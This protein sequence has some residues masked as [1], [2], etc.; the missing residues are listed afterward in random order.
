MSLNPAMT[1]LLQFQ[2]AYDYD[3][4]YLQ[5]L[6]NDAPGAFYAFSK[7]EGM[8]TQRKALP[9]EA[10][11]VARVATMLVEDC[12]PCT[13]LNLR[14]A[15]EGGVDRT[16]LETLLH[17][18]QELPQELRDVYEHAQAAVT[19]EG[20]SHERAERIK[21]AY[22]RDGFAELAVVITGCQMY[23]NLKRALLSHESCVL[24]ELEY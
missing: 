23:P 15:V 16:L 22:G 10:H 19:G 11:Y 8:S 20:L 14:M 1:E 21:R 6:L 5:G 24:G 13:Q 9:L 3:T 17:R 2:Q 12:G 4:A 18:P 7:A